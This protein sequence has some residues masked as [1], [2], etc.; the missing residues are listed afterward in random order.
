MQ[1]PVVS[2]KAILFLIDYIAA[3]GVPELK[4]DLFMLH[5]EFVLLPDPILMVDHLPLILKLGDLCLFILTKIG[6]PPSNL[7]H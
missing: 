7:L 3:H 1:Q 2:K 5:Q 4:E 6:R